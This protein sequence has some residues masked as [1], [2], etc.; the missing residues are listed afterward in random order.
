MYIEMQMSI[1]Y[2]DIGVVYLRFQTIRRSEGNA[3][4]DHYSDDTK[5]FLSRKGDNISWKFVMPAS[6]WWNGFYEHL[7]GSVNSSPKKILGLSCLTFEEME[8]MQIE[9]EN[10]INS[11]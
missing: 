3:F 4:A 8:T 6:P 11:R 5:F 1:V 2:C 7:V 10:T 9:D